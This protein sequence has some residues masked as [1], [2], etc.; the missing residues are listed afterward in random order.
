M[1]INYILTIFLTISFIW[2]ISN[3]G[4]IRHIYKETNNRKKFFLFETS[5]CTQC[6]NNYFTFLF[7]NSCLP[8]D[9]LDLDYENNESI[10][11]YAIPKYRRPKYNE[12]EESL[13]YNCRL[14]EKPVIY[15]YPNKQMP[16]TINLNITKGKLTAIY[17]K[18]NEDNNTWRINAYPNGDIEINNRKYPYLFYECFSYFEQDINEGFIVNDKN[19]EEFL[20]EKLK[21]LGLNNKEMTDFITYWLPTL[22]NNK[23]SICSFQTQK[24]FDNLQ[25]NVSPKPETIIRIF[26][27]IKKIDSPID[28]KE[29]KLEKVE[30]KGYTVVEWGGLRM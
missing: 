13:C 28:I 15:V 30:R 23:L 14:R 25:L 17:P 2:K 7:N 1:K 19:A 5:E 21:I 4:H 11:I 24:F 10:N 22:I 27:S 8:C 6:Q 9:Y 20:E 18:F 12:L 16:I 3:A 29:Q 26:L